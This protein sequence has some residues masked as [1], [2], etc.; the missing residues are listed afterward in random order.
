MRKALRSGALV[1]IGMAASVAPVLTAT[2]ASPAV[3]GAASASH[4]HLVPG[5]YH[6]PIVGKSPLPGLGSV[7]GQGAHGLRH[8]TA[9]S[10]ANWS[11]YADTNE[12]YNS[13]AATWTEPKVT[14][15]GGLGG[16]LLGGPSQASSFWVG[17]DGYNSTS[18]EQL[19]TDSD[20][21]GTKPSYY[22]WW[23]MYPNPSVTLTTPD[24]VAA[25]DQMTA[26]VVWNGTQFQLQMKDVTK[27]W[28]FSTTQSGTFAR[29]SAEVIAEAPESCTLVFCHEL[30]LA[31]FNQISFSGASVYN[32]AGTSGTLSTFPASEI[33]MASSNGTVKAQPS[34]LSTDGSAFTVTWKHS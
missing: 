29:S 25:G 4:A 21:N 17:L 22:A 32:S 34:S 30:Q 15:Q 28:T 19:G 13:V 7:L 10:S 5:I 31:N 1:L 14:C 2:A 27:G 9:V 20:C 18:V 11:G 16:G 3:A 6:D 33:T 12:T 23:E 8:A 26:W 24:T